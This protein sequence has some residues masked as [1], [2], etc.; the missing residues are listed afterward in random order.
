[1][2][3]EQKTEAGGQRTEEGAEALAACPFCGGAAEYVERRG[4]TWVRCVAC[5]AMTGCDVTGRAAAV[6]AWNMRPAR[7]ERTEFGEILAGLKDRGLITQEDID[8]LERDGMS[9]GDA[10]SAEV[11]V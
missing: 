8:R 9:R 10:E 3:G 5:G 4:E 11:Q 6:A 1:M 7:G 2:S